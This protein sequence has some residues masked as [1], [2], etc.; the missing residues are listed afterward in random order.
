MSDSLEKII[1]LI[2]NTGNNRIILDEE[3]R[4]VYVLMPFS[5]YQNLIA[6]QKECD[7]NKVSQD[8]ADWKELQ[9]QGNE[10]P[11]IDQL[12]AIESDNESNKQANQT[13]IEKDKENNKSDQRYYF[14]PID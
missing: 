1:E 5:S 9:S 11:D 13:E 10:W 12:N 2:K 8:I 7:P 3:G 4:P 14:E 6:E